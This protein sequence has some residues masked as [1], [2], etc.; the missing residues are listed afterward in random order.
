MNGF[1]GRAVAVVFVAALVSSPGCVRRT[2]TVRTEPE[3]ALILLNDEEVGLSPVT[4]D[5]TWY[6]DYDVVI[7]KEGF[8]T[9]KTHHRVSA[10]WYEYPPLD[11]FFETMVAFTLHDQHEAE[12]TLEPEQMPGRAELMENAAELRERALFT[13][14]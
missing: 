8:E 13:E 11:F 5:F 6:G 12:F 10:P 3:G 14:E 1:I 2:L 7:R 9:L 4:V